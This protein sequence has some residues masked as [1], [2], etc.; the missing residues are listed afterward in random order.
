MFHIGVAV[1]CCRLSRSFAIV[2]CG[3]R[4]SLS[5]VAVVDVFVVV[6]RASLSLIS[7]AVKIWVSS[8]FVKNVILWDWLESVA[9]LL[10]RKQVEITPLGLTI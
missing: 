7:V 10:D 1:S 9:G 3:C 6:C 5:F 4:L 2:A 8:R